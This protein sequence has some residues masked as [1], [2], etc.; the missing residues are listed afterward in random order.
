MCHL[1]HNKSMRKKVLLHSRA[2]KELSKFPR[3]VR[4]KFKALFEILQSKGKLEEPYTFSF[5]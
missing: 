3:V 2:E 5:Y 1:W 4:L